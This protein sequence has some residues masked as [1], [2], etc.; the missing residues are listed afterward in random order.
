MF[1]S[2]RLLYGYCVPHVGWSSALVWLQT[3]RPMRHCPVLFNHHTVTPSRQ[4]SALPVWHMMNIAFLSHY[5]CMLHGWGLT[6]CNT[7]YTVPT[8]TF[9]QHWSVFTINW[10]LTNG[11]ICVFQE[12]FYWPLFIWGCRLKLAAIRTSAMQLRSRWWWRWW[13]STMSLYPSL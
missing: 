8:S 5:S 1:V 11:F 13:W 10:P 3:P 12:L 7:F 9:I 6:S 2:R 4:L